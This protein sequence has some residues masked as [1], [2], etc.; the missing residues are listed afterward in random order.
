M[1]GDFSVVPLGTVSPYCKENLN[2]PGYLVQNGIYKLLLDCGPGVLRTFNYN[3]DLNNLVVV[4]SHLHHDHYA[5]LFELAYGS[6]VQNKIGNLKNKIKVL[7]PQEEEKTKAAFRL[8]NNL[9]ENYL[10]FITYNDKTSFALGNMQV[11]FLL[12]PH[13][14][15]TYSAKVKVEDKVLVYSSDTAYSFDHL[16]LFAQNADLLICESTFVTDQEK[17]EGVQHLSAFEAGMIAMSADVKQLM[18]TH[19]FPEKDKSLYVNEAKKMFENVIAAEEGK[20]LILKK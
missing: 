12:N 16:D 18:L 10:D 19:F 9:G 1:S 14:V 4:I 3:Q 8:L 11:S 5:G 15:K 17:S 7:I 6:Y 13:N 2:C 20:K